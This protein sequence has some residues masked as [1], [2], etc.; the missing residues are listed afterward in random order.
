MSKVSIWTET[1][2][3]CG[4]C[5]V[6]KPF[7]EFEKRKNGKNGIGC[8]CLICKNADM[9]SKRAAKRESMTPDQKEQAKFDRSV[10]L[11]ENKERTKATQAVW[12]LKTKATRSKM[13]ECENC[14]LMISNG[15]MWRHKKTCYGKPHPPFPVGLQFDF[16]DPIGKDFKSFRRRVTA[17]IDLFKEHGHSQNWIDKEIINR[18]KFDYYYGPIPPPCPNKIHTFD[19]NL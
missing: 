1:T 14:K 6:F 13:V 15:S 3:K 19:I 7:I 11:N 12:R 8:K 16:P 17:D 5:D 10:Y 9:R 2:R 18:A 4:T